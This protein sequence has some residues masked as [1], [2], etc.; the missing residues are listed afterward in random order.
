M[1]YATA[2]ELQS[3]VHRERHLG[4]R[5]DTVLILEHQPVYTLGRTTKL[6]DWGGNESALRTTGADLCH[7]NRGGSVTYHGPG[8]IVAYPII[9][10]NQHAAGP[11]ELVWRLEEV[12]LRL[13]ATWSIVGCRVDKKPGV[14]VMT[15]T[16]AK[17]ASV[18]LRIQQGITLHGFAI[19]VDVDLEPFQRIHPCGVPHC[20][21][22]SMATLLHT[23]IPIDEIKRDLAD[24]LSR[25][26][27]IERTLAVCTLDGYM[28][29]AGDMVPKGSSIL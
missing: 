27:A 1:S 4:L 17:I 26:F 3:R 10:L 15:P 23:E 7:V 13:L 14:W 18:G 24:I 8:Q 11:R 12:I 22:T 28:P 2:W 9:K 21:V 16:P 5:S 25:M 19:N 29:N 6:S 20:P